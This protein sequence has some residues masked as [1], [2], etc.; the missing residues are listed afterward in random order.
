M[1]KANDY[2]LFFP[3]YSVE[4]FISIVGMLTLLPANSYVS[5]LVFLAILAVMSFLT[6]L[7]FENINPWLYIIPFVLV[8]LLL[9]LFGLI[10]NFLA[11]NAILKEFYLHLTGTNSPYYLIVYLVGLVIS[12]PSAWGGSAFAKTHRI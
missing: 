1:E 4:L 3:L 8:G 11:T 7:F 12:I 2:G 9:G 5:F 10:F 6:G